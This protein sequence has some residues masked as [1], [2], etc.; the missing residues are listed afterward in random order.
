MIRVETQQ[1]KDT[2]EERRA[3]KHKMASDWCIKKNGVLNFNQTVFYFHFTH[4]ERRKN[5]KDG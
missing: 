2:K 3:E 5:R 1:E 4:M